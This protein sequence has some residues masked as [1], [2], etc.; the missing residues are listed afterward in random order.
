MAGAGIPFS[1]LRRGVLR[2]PFPFTRDEYLAGH[3]LRCTIAVAG[4]AATPH[5]ALDGGERDA[6]GDQLERDP[7][8]VLQEGFAPFQRVKPVGDISR[9][10]PE[11][12][13]GDA[14]LARSCE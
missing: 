14:E 6:R 9:L 12:S 5:A 3:Q 4:F 7:K 1:R 11:R 13:V 10:K 2:E 8:R